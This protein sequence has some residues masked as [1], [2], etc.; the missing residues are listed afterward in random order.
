MEC[1]LFALLIQRF[2]DG[3]LDAVV[4]AEYEQHRR[5]CAAC[6]GLDERYAVVA[7]AL[8]A[9][10]VY[11]PSPDFN[12]LVLARVDIAAYRASPARRVFAAVERSWNGCP[13][14]VRRG[15]VAAA[16]AALVIG[17]YKPLFDAV[18]RTVGEG[19]D[20]LWE[21]MRFMH[22]LIGAAAGVWKASGAARNYEVVGETLLRALGRPA[23]GFHPVQLIALAALAAAAA[24]VLLRSHGSARRKGETNVCVL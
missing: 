15:V 14:P 10:P 12:R 24:V 2:H 17:V 9:M 22:G 6:R 20:G 1:R 8:G 19:V 21:S 16:L 5:G 18:V 4:R 3:E 7:R 13:I 23:A 11:E